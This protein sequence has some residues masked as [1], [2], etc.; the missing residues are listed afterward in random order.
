MIMYIQQ[1]GSYHAVESM[2]SDLSI[3]P[4]ESSRCWRCQGKECPKGEGLQRLAL[5]KSH[6]HEKLRICM[7]LPTYLPRDQ[8]EYLRLISLTPR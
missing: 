6:L 2:C 7:G 4:E 3:H 8:R 1:E 5:C